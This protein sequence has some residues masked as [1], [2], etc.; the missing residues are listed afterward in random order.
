MVIKEVCGRMIDCH[1]LRAEQCPVRGRAADGGG[2]VTTRR[3]GGASYRGGL[4]PK[5][6]AGT[7]LLKEGTTTTL[8]SADPWQQLEC[9]TD[10]LMVGPI[11]GGPSVAVV[12]TTGQEAY[13][14]NSYYNYNAITADF[15]GA[16][17]QGSQLSEPTD[18]SELTFQYPYAAASSSSWGDDTPPAAQLE[19][20]LHQDRG[21][22]W[23]TADGGAHLAA[24][25]RASLAEDQ[26]PGQDVDPSWWPITDRLYETVVMVG[27][28]GGLDTSRRGLPYPLP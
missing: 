9:E 25:R 26:G 12:P 2:H 3:A 5:P 6:T 15:M 28:G 13:D 23:A 7:T 21:D 20:A 18:T 16:G 19:L 11:G 24:I 22:P 10:R 8:E 27:G 1:Q 4:W 17:G 14:D